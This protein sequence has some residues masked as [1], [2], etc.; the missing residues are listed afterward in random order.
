MNDFAGLSQQDSATGLKPDGARFAA[1]VGKQGLEPS[2]ALGTVAFKRSAE[3]NVHSGGILQTAID[4]ENCI[5]AVFVHK[6]TNHTFLVGRKTAHRTALADVT[7]VFQA[8]GLGEIHTLVFH[9]KKGFTDRQNATV[10]LAKEIPG[11]SYD[12]LVCGVVDG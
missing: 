4:N 2:D 9:I 7:R 12:I 8:L 11:G 10:D 6:M 1:L 3:V 5:S